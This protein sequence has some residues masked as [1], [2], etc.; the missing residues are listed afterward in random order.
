M[1]GG[2]FEEMMKQIGVS[3]ANISRNLEALLVEEKRQTE[4]LKE[5][6]RLVCMS[7]DAIQ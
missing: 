6:E 5:I 4:Q 1:D 2:D 3:L 7:V